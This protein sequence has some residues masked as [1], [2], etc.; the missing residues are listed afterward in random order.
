M[1]A[2]GEALAVRLALGRSIP[3]GTVAAT[4]TVEAGAVT[5]PE[6]SGDREVLGRCILG[7]GDG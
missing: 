3:P 2:A 7:I 5:L 1:T 4:P 6:E